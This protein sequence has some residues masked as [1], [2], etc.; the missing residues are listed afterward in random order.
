MSASALREPGA[1]RIALTPDG[2]ARM[3]SVSRETLDRLIAYVGLL[4]RWNQRINL[5]GRNTMADV[6]RRHILDSAQ[7]HA[8]LP[9][10]TRV[11]VDLG[12]G[13][14]LP[15]LVLA[16]MGVAEVHLLESDQRKAA[17]LREA[18]RLTTTPV[19]IHADRIEKIAS[20]KT[21]IITARAL[22]SLDELIDISERFVSDR[23]L[24]L[25]L[26]G[27]AIEAELAAAAAHWSFAVERYRSL[28]DPAGCVVKL[29]HLQRV[30][31]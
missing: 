19:T 8:L 29:E 17:F 22:A 21:D 20:F 25:F 24:C 6:W 28:A 16:I 7:L 13:A 26:K 15:G 31:A 23:T 14:G 30:A 10:R 12:S 5:V 18:S 2:F 1:A 4:E 3:V 9:P 27:A 11:L